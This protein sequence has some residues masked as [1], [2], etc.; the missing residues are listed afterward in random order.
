MSKAVLAYVNK[1]LAEAGINYE[2]GE[3]KSELVYPYFVGEY[4]ES[5][6]SEEDGL[7]ESMLIL[8]GWTTGRYAELEAAREKV[9]K[10]FTFNTTLLDD[11]S[12]VDVSY[13]GSIVIPTGN[14][15]LKRIQINLSIKLWRII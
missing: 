11:G 1:K 3:W 12:A 7:S 5:Q 8:T 6:P 13:A 15:T 2:F 10:L 14:A 4:S 9:E